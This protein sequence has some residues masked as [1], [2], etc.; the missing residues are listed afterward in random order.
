MPPGDVLET[1]VGVAY[2][3]VEAFKIVSLPDP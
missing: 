3:G 2:E 1:Y